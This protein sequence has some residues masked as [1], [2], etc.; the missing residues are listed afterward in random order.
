MTT[1]TSNIYAHQW[2]KVDP[3]P[4]NRCARIQ[5]I[6]AYVN[7]GDDLMVE[8]DEVVHLCCVVD[9][10]NMNNPELLVNIWV[11]ESILSECE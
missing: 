5:N 2:S 6:P 10:Q 1:T 4:T 8:V 9:V 3:K 7:A 11:F